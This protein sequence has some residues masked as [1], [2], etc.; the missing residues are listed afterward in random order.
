MVHRD[1]LFLAGLRKQL[2]N[3]GMH[4]MSV[5][6][7]YC[8]CD[9]RYLGPLAVVADV[10]RASACGTHSAFC[11]NQLHR[12]GRPA[13]KQKYL[14]KQ[15]VHLGEMVVRKLT[16]GSVVGMELST[17]KLGYRYLIGSEPYAETM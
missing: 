7:E 9:L 3:R 16:A 2:V 6:D 13:E 1:N 12:N 5:G 14:S 11:G 4:S 17:D 15:V 8:S 10:S